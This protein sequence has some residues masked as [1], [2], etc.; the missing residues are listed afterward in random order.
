MEHAH[1]RPSAATRSGR[2]RGRG[3]RRYFGGVGLLAAGVG[4]LAAGVGL[5]AAGVGVLVGGLS[6]CLVSRFS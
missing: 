1:I 5:L 4:L 6:P 2:S 3:A